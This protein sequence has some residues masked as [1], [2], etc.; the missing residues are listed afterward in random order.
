MQ[1]RKLFVVDQVTDDSTGCHVVGELDYG[2]FGDAYDYLANEPD[3]RAKLSAFLK[4][5]A[6]AALNGT[7]PF[8]KAVVETAKRQPGAPVAKSAVLAAPGTPPG[9]GAPV[10]P[11]RKG[12]HPLAAALVALTEWRKRRAQTPP[13]PKPMGWW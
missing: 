2:I 11:G 9:G 12:V 10:E 5:L 1:S 3:G 13:L 6:D 4:G 8:S 7:A